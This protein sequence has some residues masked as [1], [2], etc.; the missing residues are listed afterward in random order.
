VMMVE[1]VSTVQVIANASH[2][3]VLGRSD[4]RH[5]PLY[6]ERGRADRPSFHRPM[7]SLVDQRADH[8][9]HADHPDERAT[10][11]FWRAKLLVHPGQ[12]QSSAARWVKLLV[13]PD[14]GVIASHDLF[15]CG[16]SRPGRWMDGRPPY[17]I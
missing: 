17:Y 8:A 11:A 13:H 7:V 6:T 10:L 16:S 3:F 4:G 5:A 15:L 1:M 2:F 9:D 12:G 14:Q